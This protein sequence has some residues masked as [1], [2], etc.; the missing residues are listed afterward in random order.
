MGVKSHDIASPDGHVRVQH[1]APLQ[2]LSVDTLYRVPT[3]IEREFR[4]FHNRTILVT[5]ENDQFVRELCGYGAN[6]LHYPCIAFAPAPNLRPLDDG[7]RRLC[8]SR[9]D[10]LIV[11]SAQT[12][13][14]LYDRFSALNL[15][16]PPIRVAVVGQKTAGVIQSI[17]P[18]WEIITIAQHSTALWACASL[19]GARVFIPHSDLSDTTLEN[20]LCGMGINVESA[21]AY[22]TV[23]GTGGICLA[24]HPNCN[25]LTFFSPSA[26][27][28]F[29]HR[30]QSE[31][32]LVANW[33]TIPAF[34]IGQTTMQRAQEIGFT[35]V[36]GANHTQAGLLACLED[37]FLA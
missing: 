6:A 19:L 37:Y 32:V 1:V 9:F 23:I 30:A 2:P 22:R 35:Q 36:Y 5:R 17:F 28:N 15:P 3:H 8:M 24:D 31:G 21:E 25:A 27:T 29:I 14:V 18:T 26:V 20:G 10:T 7:L 16:I 12:A 4:P 33:L 34:C 13:R 11:T